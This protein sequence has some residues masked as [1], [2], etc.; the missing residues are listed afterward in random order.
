MRFPSII[1]GENRMK[2]SFALVE[3]LAKPIK[4]SGINSLNG[5]KR[6]ITCP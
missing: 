1:F 4:A 5:Q 3:E 6:K 2:K